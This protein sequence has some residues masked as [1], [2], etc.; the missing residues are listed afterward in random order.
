MSDAEEDVSGI[1]SMLR[2]LVTSVLRSVWDRLNQV[3]K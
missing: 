3:E 2:D 1:T